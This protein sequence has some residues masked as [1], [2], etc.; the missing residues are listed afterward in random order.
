MIFNLLNYITGTVTV[1]VRGAM[2][3]KFINLCM[4][5][6]KSLLSINTQKGEFIVCMKLADF[7]SIRPLVRKSRNRIQVIGYSGL[8]FGIRKMKQRKMLIVG[9]AIF[10]ILLNVLMSYIWFVDIIGVNSIPTYQIQ[11]F[12]YE[13]GLK[14]G[15]LKEEINAKNIEKQLL[16]SMSEIAW[17]SIRFTGTRAVVE[18]V[19]K[20][21]SKEQDKAPAHIVAGKDGVITEVIALTGESIV[22]KG[23]TV[24]KGDVLIKGINNASNQL[25]RANGI[26]KARVWYEAYGETELQNIIYERTGKQEFG[27][28]LRVGAYEILLKKPIIHP[29]EQFEVEVM[30]KK[31]SWW[32]NSDITVESIISTYYEVNAKR[33]ELTLEEAREVGKRKA[34]AEVQSLIPETAQVLTRTVDILKIPETNLVRVKVSVETAEDIGQFL[35][36]YE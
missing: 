3:E 27:V 30:N 19:E 25:I 7:L 4:M 33:N 22:K 35:T 31:V 10:L 16:V 36:I 17:V 9:G 23:D 29:E 2:P 8:P 21:M 32:R 18:I 24:K 13:N 1:R 14:P 5:D 20:T 11:S 26:I 15:R 28:A 6:K 12:L 34:L